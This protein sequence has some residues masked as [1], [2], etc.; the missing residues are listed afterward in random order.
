MAQI[1]L[2]GDH[3]NSANYKPVIHY[4]PGVTGAWIYD[5]QDYLFAIGWQGSRSLSAEVTR[6]VFFKQRKKIACSDM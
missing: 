1:D 3:C 4:F 2:R 5:L 6:T